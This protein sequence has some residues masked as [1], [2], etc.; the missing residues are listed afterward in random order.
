M[1]RSVS[2]PLAR[3]LRTY[4][5]SSR[6]SPF[7]RN[8][9]VASLT[10]AISGIA[11]VSSF[12]SQR[13]RADARDGLPDVLRNKNVKESVLDQPS[14]KEDIH[15]RHGES[16]QSSCHPN[17]PVLACVGFI[18]KRAL[19]VESEVKATPRV[20]EGKAEE[21][22]EEAQGAFN[23]ETGEINWDC[24]VSSRSLIC[25]RIRRPYT[26]G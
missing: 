18:D 20:V 15:K 7:G 19:L 25:S 1:I 10:L 5:T 17:V 12:D 24:P 4:S 14:L 13:L 3:T 16:H 9:A 21:A 2:R 11:Y 23:E 22:S 8:A 26:T 6:S